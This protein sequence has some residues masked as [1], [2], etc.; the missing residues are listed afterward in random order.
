MTSAER[1][2]S[3]FHNLLFKEPHSLGLR[4]QVARWL[5]ERDFHFN[6]QSDHLIVQLGFSSI[7]IFCYRVMLPS[8]PCICITLEA[9]IL[10]PAGSDFLDDEELGQLNRDLPLGKLVRLGENHIL[11]VNH[12]LA[13]GLTEEDFFR[14]LELFRRGI[15]SADS[16]VARSLS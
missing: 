15:H 16:M 14:H 2:P 4:I 11:L 3:P 7:A 10:G 9:H 5:R 13:E 12:I 6:E 1:H 8:Q